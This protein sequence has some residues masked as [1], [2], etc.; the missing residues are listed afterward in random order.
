MNNWE[1]TKHG[2]YRRTR[3]P[4]R[5]RTSEDAGR[6]DTRKAVESAQTMDKGK[7]R[8]VVH[9]LRVKYLRRNLGRGSSPS[10][11]AK[12][13][14]FKWRE[15]LGLPDCP[16]LIRW[17]LE[18]PWGSV[19]LHHWLSHDDDRALHDH[20]WDFVTFVLRG[21]YTD[22]GK[23]TEEHL[24]APAIKYRSAT[25]QHTVHPDPGGCWTIIFT[26]PKVRNWGFW[27]KDKFVKMNKYFLTYGHH[28]CDTGDE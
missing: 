24:R 21:G 1:P 20:P 26:G 7:I 3:V 17:R 15:Q 13:F 4:Q 5:Q 19:R 6:S 16:Y 25:H 22:S 14:I 2:G 12:R 8:T 10:P 11:R 28:P 9:D 23:Y 27:V 18:T